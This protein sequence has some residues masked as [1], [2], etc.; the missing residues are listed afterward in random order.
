LPDISTFCA[1][2]GVK[3]MVI[4]TR[5]ITIRGIDFIGL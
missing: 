1:E 2:M 5:K 4:D 3:I